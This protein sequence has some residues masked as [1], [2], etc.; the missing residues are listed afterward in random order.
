MGELIDFEAARRRRGA[1]DGGRCALCGGP[2]AVCCSRGLCST[3]L[4]EAVVYRQGEVLAVRPE[5]MAAAIRE[6]AQKQLT[7]E[8]TAEV[9]YGPDVCPHCGCEPPLFRRA[10]AARDGWW[11][12]N[13]C[14]RQEQVTSGG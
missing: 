5:V 12:C 13:E 9:Q 4:R 11:Y 8:P 10:S 14:G 6:M 1:G 7:G 3:V 2:R